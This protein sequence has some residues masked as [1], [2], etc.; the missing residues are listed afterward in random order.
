[1]RILEFPLSFV[2]CDADDVGSHTK[3]AQFTRSFVLVKRD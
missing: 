2:A 3:K 1:L